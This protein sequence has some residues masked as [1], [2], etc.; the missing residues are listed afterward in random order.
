MRLVPH[1]AVS[2]HHAEQTFERSFL[3]NKRSR[4]TSDHCSHYYDRVHFQILL[5]PV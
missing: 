1:A 3:Q 4:K 5:A 2:I